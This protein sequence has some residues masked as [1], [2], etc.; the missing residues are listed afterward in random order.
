MILLDQSN[1]KTLAPNESVTVEILP[2]I[3]SAKYSPRDFTGEI[4]VAADNGLPQVIPIR[5]AAVGQE[6]SKND[7]DVTAVSNIDAVTSIVDRITITND[8]DRPMD[9]VKLMLSSNLDR[10]LQLSENT[11]KTIA[12]GEA[13]DVYLSFRA[14]LGDKK[15]MFMRNYDGELTVISEHHNQK[16]IPIKL[17]WNRVESDHFITYARNSDEKIANEMVEVLEDNFVKVTSR[18]GEPYSKT[19]IFIASNSEEMSLVAHSANSYYSYA[20]DT[21][22]VCACEEPAYNA[23]KEFIYRT[24]VQTSVTYYNM[25]ALTFHDENWLLDGIAEYAASEIM[26]QDAADRI[27]EDRLVS[28][29]W[30]GSG[31]DMQHVGTYGFLDY[32]EAEYGRDVTGKL[33][34]SLSYSITTNHKCSSVEECS[35]LN[36]VYEV[37]GWDLDKRRYTLSFNDIVAGWKESLQNS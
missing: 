3:D 25:K 8:G 29:E 11:F 20:D 35:I 6:D 33:V 21:V 17:E 31:S 36:A 19:S 34:E 23:M 10:V 16:K 15:E 1:I 18:F 7:F 14:E 32:L 28:F 37:N 30:H 5:I 2:R 27:A 9:S 12:S 4:I 26:G 13:V 24:I 22:F